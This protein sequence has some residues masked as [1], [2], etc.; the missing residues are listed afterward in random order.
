MQWAARGNGFSVLPEN[1]VTL[2]KILYQ[3]W[4]IKVIL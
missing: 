2:R 3:Q 4:R 1:E